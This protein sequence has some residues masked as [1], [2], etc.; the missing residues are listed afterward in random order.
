MRLPLYLALLLATLPL[1]AA[2]VSFSNIPSTNTV[3]VT[4]LMLIDSTLGG[5]NYA[6]RTVTATNFLTQLRVAPTFA[7][8]TNAAGIFTGNTTKAVSGAGSLVTLPTDTTANWTASGTT[9]STLIGAATVGSSFSTN[10]FSGGGWYNV[11]DPRFGAIG[12]GTNDDTA[13]I[14]AAIDAPGGNGAITYF[15]PGKYK[16]TS[17]LTLRNQT[18]LVG[19]GN[20]Y[21]YGYSSSTNYVSL[22]DASTVTDLFAIMSING[23]APR[24]E[25]LGLKGP[26][27]AGASGKYGVYLGGTMGATFRNF[28]V[29][30][31]GYGIGLAGATGTR[32]DGVES[33]IAYN[34]GL[35]LDSAGGV[36]ATGDNFANSTGGSSILMKD[37]VNCNFIDCVIDESTT[38]T[39]QIL[40]GSNITI[41][42]STVFTSP[43]SGITLGM[44]SSSSNYASAVTLMNVLVRPFS[45]AEHATNTIV[46]LGGRDNRLINVLTYPNGNGDISNSGTNTLYVNVNGSYTIPANKFG[47]GSAASPSVAFGGNGGTG[48]YSDSVDSTVALTIGGNRQASWGTGGLSILDNSSYITFGASTDLALHRASS[49][50]LAVTAGNLSTL[51]TIQAESVMLGTNVLSYSGTNLTWNGTTI[52]VP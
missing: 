39:V 50:V 23:I 48:W 20:S 12:D 46:I 52:T 13:A 16:I 40:G 15:P 36:T 21:R 35:Y 27:G 3:N 43:L 11:K 25:Q 4:D 24:I 29:C 45:L 1:G 34:A 30:G 32:L 42:G 31:F 33:Q 17:Q 14:Q 26:T 38:H 2:T 5:T 49:S 9:N 47:V 19:A 51:K 18:A 28:Y 7:N 22:I 44:S 41:Y 37:A 6:T 8:W 10:G